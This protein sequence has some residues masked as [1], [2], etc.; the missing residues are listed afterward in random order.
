MRRLFLVLLLL[1][2]S[3]RAE[4][5]WFVYD[6]SLAR[7]SS[8]RAEVR[9]ERELTQ[10]LALPPLWSDIEQLIPDPLQLFRTNSDEGSRDGVLV[11]DKR[12]PEQAVF[13][14][15]ELNSYSTIWQAG[16]YLVQL[17]AD[18]CRVRRLDSGEGID[19]APELARRL[20]VDPKLEQLTRRM[21]PESYD[22]AGWSPGVRAVRDGRIL[23]EMSYAFS[24]GGVGRQDAPA[25]AR[26]LILYPDASRVGELGRFQEPAWATWPLPDGRL[27]FVGEGF[28]RLW[29]GSQLVT[30]PGIKSEESPSRL[31][32][33]RLP[34]PP[35]HLRFV[36]QRPLMS[37]VSLVEIPL[38]EPA[39]VLARFWGGY[40]QWGTG[41]GDHVLL[42]VNDGLEERS[43]T[44]T[45]LR[46]LPFPDGQFVGAVTEG[47]LLVNDQGY[48]FFEYAT[49]R[50]Q[51][52]PIRDP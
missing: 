48:V 9:V 25:Q 24:G 12:H 4:D 19:L 30:V 16:P 36:L 33:F 17:A 39:R 37:D 31:S 40:V 5:L 1:T 42:L 46:R 35:G 49:G 21:V 26:L 20:V 11:F 34:A 50:L 13:Q 23:F 44:G 8:E 47:V 10:K 15:W 29:D 6:R 43:L 38:G 28:V 7:F 2:S 51:S 41:V 32:V 27:S 14:P 22:G 52:I 3:A 18:V 45:V